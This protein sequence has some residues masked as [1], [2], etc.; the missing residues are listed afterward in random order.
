M[1]EKEGNGERKTEREKEGKRERKKEREKGRKEERKIKS[2]PV[3]TRDNRVLKGP[4]GRSLCLFA[5]IAYSAHL[6]HSVL[7]P[8]A[9]SVHGL[10]HSLC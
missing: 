10:A 5:R 2:R 3:S 6:L 9:P 4:L 1:R 7:L 8:Y